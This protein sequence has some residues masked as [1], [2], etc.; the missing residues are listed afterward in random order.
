[1]QRDY[2]VAVELHSFTIDRMVGIARSL[3]YD[4][5]TAALAKLYG[6]VLAREHAIDVIAAAML[7]GPAYNAFGIEQID[8]DGLTDPRDYS[9]HRVLMGD[10]WWQRLC[11][12][13]CER[14]GPLMRFTDKIAHNYD[15]EG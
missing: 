6:R 15:F 1:M 3:R 7:L 14:R 2:Q 12:Y 8:I 5:R 11:R 10:D 9:I 4:S 13:A